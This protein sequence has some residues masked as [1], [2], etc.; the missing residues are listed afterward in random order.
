MTPLAPLI[1]R[2][3]REYMP[4]QRGYSPETCDTY[5]VSFRLLL[6]YAAAKLGIRPSKLFIEQLNA[7]LNVDFLAHIEQERR[8]QR[9]YPQPALGGDPG[10]HALRRVPGAVSA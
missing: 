7:P 8:E 3:L 10:V 6:E 1:T 2:F 5:A 9:R 4:G